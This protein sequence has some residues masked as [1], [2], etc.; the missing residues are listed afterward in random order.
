M[1]IPAPIIPDPESLDDAP[2]VAP[3]LR[4]AMTII[5]EEQ[6][7][8]IDSYKE[9]FA[10]FDRKYKWGEVLFQLTNK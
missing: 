8:K 3:N 6:R 7:E 4:P 1:Q 5:P 10:Q 2:G 9:A